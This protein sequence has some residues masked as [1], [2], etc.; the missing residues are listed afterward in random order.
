MDLHTPMYE[1]TIKEAEAYDLF[2]VSGPQCT[3]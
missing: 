3:H 1:Q 2:C